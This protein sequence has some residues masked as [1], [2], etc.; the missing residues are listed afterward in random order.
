MR[1]ADSYCVYTERFEKGNHVYGFTG[2]CVKCTKH[3]TVT[4]PGPG[5]YRYRQGDHIQDAFPTL[6][7]SDREFLMSGICSSCWDQ[8]FKEED[9]E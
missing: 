8:M 6:S 5:L 3:V 4:V 1:Y 7:P 2:P 9:E